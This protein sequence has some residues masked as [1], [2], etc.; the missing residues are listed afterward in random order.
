MKEK[1]VSLTQRTVRG[2]MWTF[3]EQLGQMVLKIVVFA[4]L[5]RLLG[6]Q[7]FGL[8]SA[9]MVIIG[10]VDV[11]G[12][13]GMAPALIQRLELSD[14]HIQSS[15][16]FSV[17]F[18]LSAGAVVFLSAPLL[19]DGFSMPAL[20]PV[21]QGMALLFPIKGLSITAE[22]LIQ[23]QMRFS[24][25]TRVTIGTYLFGY[26]G[27]SIGLAAFGWGVW[28]LVWGQLAQTILMTMAYLWLARHSI[29]TKLHGP[30]LRDL[31]GFGAG[32][33]LAQ[34]GNYIAI[35]VDNFV[36]GR[37]LGAGALGF[38]S[39][40]YAFMMMATIMFGT[41]VDRALFPAM[42]SIQDE[43][44]KLRGAY[45]Q[46]LG[47]VFATTLPLS[48]FML[49][50]APQLI[51]FM[52]GPKWTAAIVPFQILIATLVCRTG[53]KMCDIV[54]RAKGA[55]F[56]GAW[57]QWLYAGEVLV[58]SYIGQFWGITGVAI[59]VA[60]S[61]V[62]HFGTMLHL[63]RKVTG[64]PWMAVFQVAAQNLP[65]TLLIVV[66]AGAVR[67]AGQHASIDNLSIFLLAA[68]AC[69]GVYGFFWFFKRSF[70]GPDFEALR[71]VAAVQVGI[72]FRRHG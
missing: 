62:I 43:A 65:T 1:K 42:A 26:A 27:V 46:A 23:R 56:R 66:V 17:L 49:I 11:F 30:S 19:A 63:A 51:P 12:R 15:F 59:A 10:F 37:F 52:L 16:I 8:M 72:I 44:D 55:I 6:P 45:R 33:S 25:M 9:A 54:L 68:I 39:R 58:G 40:S 64:L 53:Y 38:Y 18:G 24:E 22:A 57:R 28:S 14:L 48:G 29:A 34:V 21:M 13:L 31:L 5:G 41:V 7:D 50:M 4:V 60:L 71:S 61:I 67:I 3:T 69:M 47:F 20:K 70:L 32:I 2:L 36:V 35:N